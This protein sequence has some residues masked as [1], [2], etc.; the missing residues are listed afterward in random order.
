MLEPDAIVMQMT[1]VML[2]A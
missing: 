2:L 1:V